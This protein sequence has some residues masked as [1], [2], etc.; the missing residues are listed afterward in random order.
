MVIDAARIS[1]HRQFIIITPQDMRF[2]FLSFFFKI[3]FF[4]LI[5][6]TSFSHV[7]IGEDVTVVRLDPPERGASQRS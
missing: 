2:F 7:E 3:I 1:K 6:S 4:L 5:H